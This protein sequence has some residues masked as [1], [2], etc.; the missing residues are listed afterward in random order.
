MNMSWRSTEDSY[1]PERMNA[2]PHHGAAV[3]LAH[4]LFAV[5]IQHPDYAENP[6]EYRLP[7]GAE[8]RDLGWKRPP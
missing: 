2:G 3:P 7:I 6:Q 8:I 5:T 1:V 4:D